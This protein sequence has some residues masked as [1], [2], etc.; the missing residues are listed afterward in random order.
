MTQPPNTGRGKNK[1][2]NILLIEKHLAFIECGMVGAVEVNVDRLDDGKCA[3]SSPEH[4]WDLL[5]TCKYVADIDE[6]AD[7][8]LELPHIEAR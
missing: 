4:C 3:M 5:I 1:N 8:E 2:K 6:N 7:L